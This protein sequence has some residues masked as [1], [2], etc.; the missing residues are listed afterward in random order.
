M[1]WA[2]R[3]TTE[4]LEKYVKK[5]EELVEKLGGLPVKYDPGFGAKLGIS[6]YLTAKH[7]LEK[8]KKNEQ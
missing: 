6:S 3:L 4:Q 1:T 8:R 2:E 5:G 7:E